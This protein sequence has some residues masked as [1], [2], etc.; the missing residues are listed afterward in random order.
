MNNIKTKTAGCFLGL[1]IGDALGTT[2][3]FAWRDEQPEL[4]EIVGGGPFKLEPG[5][6]TDDTSMALC[7]AESLIEKE[8]F[9]PRDQLTRYLK[10]Y[11]T[12]YNS[13]NGRCFDIG[14]TTLTALE[15][16][17]D[18]DC[19][20]CGSTAPDTAG[21]GSIMRIAPVIIRYWQN[22]EELLKYSALSSKTTHAAK[23][24]VQASQIMALFI[25]GMFKGM[26]RK[27]L[28]SD[29]FGNYILSKIPD[30]SPKLKI[31]VN[32]SYRKII[33]DRVSSSGYVVDTLEAALWSFYNARFFSEAIILAVNLA[34]DADTVGAVTGQIAGAYWGYNR[35]M[36]Y[37][38]KKIY[39]KERFIEMARELAGL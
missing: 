34:R 16:F 39:E 4:T 33:R 37:F 17:E 27:E 30:L 35:D 3:E 1:A 22:E 13:S 38:A 9:D 25:A 6:W 11:R 26:K 36:E 7:L 19:E 10:W 20:Y 29:E 24:A 5:E 2:L 28:F 15:M 32:G 8:Q 18:T 14:Y 12:G 23:E 21:N 31:V